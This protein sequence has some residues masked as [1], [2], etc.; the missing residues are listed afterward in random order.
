LNGDDLVTI[1]LQRRND[2]AETRTI[3]PDAVAENDRW[4]G[5][6]RHTAFPFSCMSL[7]DG[8]M[9]EGLERGCQG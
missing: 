5:L 2:F 6:C 1:S 4:F 9:L 7:S 3:G 8:G